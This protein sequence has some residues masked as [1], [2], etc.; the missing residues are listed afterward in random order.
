VFLYPADS[1]NRDAG[2]KL[3]LMY[4]ANPMAMIIERA[5]GAAST[6][7]GPIMDIQPS[8]PHQRVPVILG[9]RSEVERLVEYHTEADSP[10]H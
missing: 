9:S 4:E 7:F 10:E 8:G 1:N 6:G 2:G 3:R 5:G